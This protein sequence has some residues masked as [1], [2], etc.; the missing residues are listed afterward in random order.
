MNYKLE[1]E[2]LIPTDS[3][4]PVYININKDKSNFEKKK[5]L[6]FIYP[7]NI[8]LCFDNS[9]KYKSTDD[10]YKCFILLNMSY[11]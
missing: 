8:L 5:S 9:L 11:K 2:Y 6:L 4:Y 7:G 3:S 10:K 1:V